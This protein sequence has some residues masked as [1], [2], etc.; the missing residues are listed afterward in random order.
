MGDSGER[1]LVLARPASKAAADARRTSVRVR[2]DQA[3]GLLAELLRRPRRGDQ[4]GSLATAFARPELGHGLLDGHESS[5]SSEPLATADGLL[6]DLLRR[7]AGE[8]SPAEA[9]EYRVLTES[10]PIGWAAPPP[11]VEVAPLPAAVPTRRA[12]TTT[13]AQHARQ[14]APGT[15]GAVTADRP[16]SAAAPGGRADGHRFGSDHRG[17]RAC[18][19]RARAAAQDLR[20]SCGLR[21]SPAR[22]GASGVA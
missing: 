9:D 2:D 11:L 15:A 18:D 8:S 22:P 20:V 12:I 1:D 17:S 16:V 21:R 6:G 7:G 5:E 10:E 19:L 3:S 13:G 4:L 14:A